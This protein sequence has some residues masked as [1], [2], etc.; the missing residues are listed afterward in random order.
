[1]SDS[2]AIP[3]FQQRPNP[4][5][6]NFPASLR[7]YLAAGHFVTQGAELSLDYRTQWLSTSLGYAYQDAD[8]LP[9]VA[10]WNA[11][12]RPHT[13]D[14][15]VTFHAPAELKTGLLSRASLWIGFRLASGTAYSACDD[16]FQ[17]LADP[18]TLSDEPCVGG[19]VF[20]TERL[21]MEKQLDLRFSKALGDAPYAPRVFIDA[22][23]ALNFGNTIRTF[24]NADLVAAGRD[25]LAQGE[26][27]GLAA[28][29][30]ANGAY[31]Q[32]DGTIDLTFPG[33][34][35]ATWVNS[36]A[37]VGAAPSCIAL[38]RAEARYGNG[39]GAYTLDEQRTAV[40]A[41]LDATVG[42][43]RFGPPRRIRIGV[44]L[45]I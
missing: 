39:D 28:E 34:G 13:M 31:S 23:N 35:C 40:N 45:G 38:K 14:A 24:R 7:L 22:R 41:L 3:S 43:G 25:Q 8:P 29:A 17:P 42:Q 44:E 12:S 36:A 10:S 4:T 21:P 2:L 16:L 15:T 20:Q 26:L 6:N 11:W 30:Q 18:F 1:V 33:A 32:S 37:N 9:Q 27:E 19:S 5:R